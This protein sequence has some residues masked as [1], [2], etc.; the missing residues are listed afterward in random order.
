VERDS[1]EITGTNVDLVNGQIEIE[2]G[3]LSSATDTSVDK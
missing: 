3:D 1:I 2:F